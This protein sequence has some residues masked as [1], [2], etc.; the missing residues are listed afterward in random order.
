MPD[1]TIKSKR[2]IKGSFVIIG[3]VLMLTLVLFIPFPSLMLDILWGLNL[4]LVLLT[5]LII[6]HFKKV[7]DLS[8][9]PTC[10]LILTI[11]SLLIQISFASLI[12]TKGEA[13]DSW[14]IH[15]LSLLMMLLGGIQDLI[16]GAITF[17]IFNIVIAL[18][19]TKA[20]T[21][22]SEVAARVSLY[23]L[24]G[25]QMTIDTE[26]ASGTITEEEAI[27]RKNDLQHE[28]DF[29]GAMD[30]ASKFISGYLKACLFITALSIIGGIAIGTLFK[31]ETI[32]N[33]MMTYMPLSFCN[34]FLALLICF[35]ESNIVGITV[36]KAVLTNEFYKE[37]L[38]PPDPIRIELGFGL[39]PLVDK[40]RGANFLELLKKNAPSAYRGVGNK[41]S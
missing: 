31:G 21:R 18:I 39:I 20:C 24:P 22:V 4:L 36:T 3:G 38:S 26:Y 17:I 30:G 5:F 14:I 37:P 12:L 1:E 25:K 35:M 10:L 40:G 9:L 32:Y 15:T 16:T 29:Y 11:F 7:N 41:N 27:A 28:S 19:F 6:L 2:P 13:L 33:A 8:L 23:F 34:G